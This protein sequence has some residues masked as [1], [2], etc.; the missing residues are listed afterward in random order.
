MCKTSNF[1]LRTYKIQKPQWLLAFIP[2]YS[3]NK[4][5]LL[6][7]GFLQ[8]FIGN[9]RLT[10]DCLSPQGS[11]SLPLLCVCMLCTAVW[12]LWWNWAAPPQSTSPCL[13]L[14]SSASSVGSSSSSTMWADTH[15]Q[16]FPSLIGLVWRFLVRKSNKKIDTTTIVCVWYSFYTHTRTHAHTHARTYTHTLQFISPQS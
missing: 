16:K 2:K 15:I 12:P 5:V 3:R 13:P 8:H 9:C 14:T 6:L 10:A 4:R 7:Q 1:V 11:C